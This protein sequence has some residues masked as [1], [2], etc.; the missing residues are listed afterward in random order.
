MSEAKSAFDIITS[1][2]VPADVYLNSVFEIETILLRIRELNDNIQHLK[3]LK[4]FRVES[5]DV[6]IKHLEYKVVQFRELIERTMLT[7]EPDQK[8]LQFPSVAKISRRTDKG[9]WVIS[10]EDAFVEFLNKEGKKDSLVTVKEVLN[11]RL[12]KKVAAEYAND[13]QVPPGVNKVEAST[14]LSITFEDKPKLSPS[15]IKEV[16]KLQ[17]V[18]ESTEKPTQSLD[19]LESLEV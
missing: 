17:T 4:K 12:A 19:D 16:D 5:A 18:K 8:T 1:G 7:L 14:S 6:E 2:A 3:G 11:K 9:G 15:S 13:G 10:D